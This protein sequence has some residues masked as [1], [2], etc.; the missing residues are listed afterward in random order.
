MKWN[1]MNIYAVDES[2]FYSWVE[3]LSEKELKSLIVLIEL[4][5]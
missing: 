4:G 1:F 2:D 3:S 5:R